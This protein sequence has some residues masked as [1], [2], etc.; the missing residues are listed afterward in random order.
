MSYN[1]GDL[2]W[3]SN[4]LGEASG[5]ITWNMDLSSGLSFDG[6]VYGVDDFEDAMTAAFDR[7]E[8][9]ADIDFTFTTDAS[10]NVEVSMGYLAGSTVGLASY[11]YYP[12]PEV[13][14]I[15]DADITMDSDVFW[16]PYGGGGLDFYAVAL[17]EVGHILGLGH[18]NDTSEI[19]N[20]YVSTDALGDGDISGVQLLYGSGGAAAPPA[21]DPAPSDP[22]PAAPGDDGGGGGGVG[23]IIGLLA[24]IIGAVFGMGGGA[25]IALAASTKD[26]DAPEDDATE[27]PVDLADLLP[28]VEFDAH[29]LYA[30]EEDWLAADGHLHDDHDDDDYIDALF[31]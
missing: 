18:V 10:A 28:I 26:D 1:A 14:R 22:P 4:T 13:D 29:E 17:H 3:G 8:Q 20:P 12:D 9:A 15:F 16:S 2:K 21:D 31:L 6:S 11:S 7:W 19:M 24:L 25:A 30:N 27:D 5:E 23:A